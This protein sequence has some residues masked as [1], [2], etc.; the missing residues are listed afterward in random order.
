MDRSIYIGDKT[1]PRPLR[2]HPQRGRGGQTYQHYFCE[3]KYAARSAM[4]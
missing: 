1:P 2:G 4:S 3:E